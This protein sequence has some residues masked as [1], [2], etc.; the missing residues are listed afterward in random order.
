M[1][2]NL[3]IVLFHG[4]PYCNKKKIHL[5][6]QRFKKSKQYNSPNDHLKIN[7][8]R[9]N[10]SGKTKGHCPGVCFRCN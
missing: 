10:A 3:W 8:I 1:D 5:N 9:Y 4:F 7:W 2:N 6:L